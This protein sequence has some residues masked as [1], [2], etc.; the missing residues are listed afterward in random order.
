MSVNNAKKLHDNLIAIDKSF[1]EMMQKDNGI[2]SIKIEDANVMWDNS[3]I[4][5]MMP[6]YGNVWAEHENIDF[7]HYFNLPKEESVVSDVNYQKFAATKGDIT[8]YYAFSNYVNFMENFA[9]RDL[10]DKNNT[11]VQNLMNKVFAIYE[12]F[13]GV[14]TVMSCDFENGKI[15]AKSQMFYETKEDEQRYAEI[16]NFADAKLSGEFL[17]YVSQNP[18]LLMTMDFDGEKIINMIDKFGFTEYLDTIRIKKDIDV[19]TLINSIK[20]DFILSVNNVNLGNSTMP[21][22]I[23]VFAKLCNADAFKTEF[24]KLLKD[25]KD[26]D[27]LNFGVKN[28]VFYLFS[29]DNAKQLFETGAENVLMK[30]INGQPMFFYGD[31]SNLKESLQPLYAYQAFAPLIDKGLSLVETFESKYIDKDNGEFIINFT[32][33]KQNSLKQIFVFINEALNKVPL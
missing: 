17:K 29:N 1:E 18:H 22:S 15:I 16:Y 10:I 6:Y 13:K 7:A 8:I 26:I 31:L 23:S 11:E 20:G 33:K 32:D 27:F 24:D 9:N 30:K 28:D 25:S 21:V 14:S 5:L 4:L 19:K 12:S 2:Y 3:K